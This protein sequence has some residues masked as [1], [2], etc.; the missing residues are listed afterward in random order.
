[1]GQTHTH[2]HRHKFVGATVH[3]SLI[4]WINFMKKIFTF[5]IFCLYRIWKILFAVY[6][7]KMPWPTEMTWPP[8]FFYHMKSINEQP[9]CKRESL[10]TTTWNT[11]SL[12]ETWS[13]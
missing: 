8:A 7:K 13:P 4:G 9:N 10:V 6:A 3:R 11:D 1:M 2:T 12:S 5:V